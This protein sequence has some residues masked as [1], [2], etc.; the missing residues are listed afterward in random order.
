MSMESR[1]GANEATRVISG[2]PARALSPEHPALAVLAL[3]RKRPRP[4]RDLSGPHETGNG[5]GRLGDLL[6]GAGP[7]GLDRLTDTGVEVVAHQLD[8]HRLQCL[9]RG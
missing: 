8:G 1:H 7:T 2:T 6:L 9:G 4:I 3:H 5:I